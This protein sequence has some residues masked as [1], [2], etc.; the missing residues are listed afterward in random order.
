MSAF[1]IFVVA[2]FIIYALALIGSVIDALFLMITGLIRLESDTFW[3]GVKIFI[4]TIIGAVIFI[5]LL[6][7]APDNIGFGDTAIKGKIPSNW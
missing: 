1:Q 3:E 6:R 2:F 7:Y 5:V 4:G